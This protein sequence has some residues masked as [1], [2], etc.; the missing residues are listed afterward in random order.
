[1]QKI[2]IPLL[3][4]VLQVSVA[5]QN[6]IRSELTTLLDTPWEIIYGPDGFLWLTEAGGKVVRVDPA[7][8]AKTVIYTAPDYFPG[9]DSETS[10]LCFL[11]KIGSGTLG[12]ALHP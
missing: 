4:L 9:A 5:A 7:T 6:F 8:G 3:I 12:M 1:M 11:P 10:T 2:F